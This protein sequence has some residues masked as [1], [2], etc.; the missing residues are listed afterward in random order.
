M[1]STDSNIE[2]QQ[3]TCDN[4]AVIEESQQAEGESVNDENQNKEK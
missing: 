2:E 3:V 4:S 1:E